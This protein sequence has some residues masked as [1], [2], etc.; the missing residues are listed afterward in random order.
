MVCVTS[1]FFCTWYCHWLESFLR[2]WSF[3]RGRCGFHRSFS[4]WCGGFVTG[5]RFWFLCI[6]PSHRCHLYAFV[7]GRYIA[8]IVLGAC[9]LLPVAEEKIEDN[10]GQDNRRDEE[11]DHENDKSDGPSVLGPIL[12]VIFMVS[13]GATS[14]S[15]R[16][17]SISVVDAR[18]A[19]L[20]A[21]VC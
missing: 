13:H 19:V 12:L 16:A 2:R 3:R 14:F 7:G 11:D 4:R 20:A 17:P 21:R 10:D 6:R 18:R 8:T 5:R 1:Y 15:A 9:R